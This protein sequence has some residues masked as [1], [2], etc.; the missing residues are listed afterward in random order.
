MLTISIVLYK[1]SPCDLIGLFSD[2]V[3]LEA[4]CDITLCL[5]NNGGSEWIE[6]YAAQRHNVLVIHAGQ[7]RG[8]G[9]GHNLAIHA[10]VGRSTYVLI[11]NP[12]IRFS[13]HDVVA[14]CKYADCSPSGLF[15]PQVLYPEGQRQELCKLLP[16]PANLFVRRFMPW[17]ANYLDEEYLLRKADFNQS[18]FVPS[19]SGCFMLFKAKALLE[20]GGFDERYFMYLEDVDL[21]RRMA[22]K[23]GVT[24]VPQATVTHD[25]QKASYK[26]YRMLFVHITS[27]IRYFN[28]WGWF[29]DK[30]RDVLNQK[31]LQNLPLP[32]NSKG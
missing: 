18:F 25:F 30:N 16:T 21:S 13:P 31:C 20:V 5:V 9:A 27:A 1:H 32:P 10:Q 6:E 7:N 19:V 24:F 29:V 8:Y 17:F 11:C 3:Q 22:D 2:I 23:Y 28:K 26:N 4:L 15:M 14:L 12:D